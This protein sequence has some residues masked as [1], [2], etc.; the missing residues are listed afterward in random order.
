MISYSNWAV[1]S[2]NFL[3]VLCLSFAG[4]ALSS[5]LYLVGAKWRFEVRQIAVSLFALFPLA[6]VLLIILLVGGEHTFP[7]IGHTTHGEDVHMPG[8]YTLP[9]L[10]AREIIGMLTV[11]Y[12]SWIFIKRQA[13]SER[14][15]EDA[16]R[17][18]TIATW[19]P[20]FYVLYGTMVAW[21]FEMTLKPSWHS[22]IYGMQNIVSNFGMFLAF[23][24]IWIYVLNTRDKLVK[25]VK[26]YIYNYLAQMMLA[27]TLLW[28]Y[29][30]FA[31]YLTIWYGNIGDEVDRVMGMQNGDYS[32]LWWA[33]IFMKFVIPFSVLA[34]P[35]SR[36]TP[37]VILG[38]AGSI[39]LGTLCERYTW[40]AGVNGTGTIPV[41]WG[42][43][44][45]AVVAFIGYKLVGGAMRRNHLIKG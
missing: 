9:L 6:F 4:V 41:L 31:Q 19:I 44:V 35:R 18:H 32:V 39:I 40:V 1:L 21:D 10:A 12:L 36:H 30:F 38:V 24:M 17:F 20:F 34:F 26:E 8:W 28:M 43:V 22:A 23:L 13:V 33:M 16:A 29:T 14:S 25:Q 5:V 37:A 42:I 15:K 11:I 7:W 3:V 27:F 2:V 45:T